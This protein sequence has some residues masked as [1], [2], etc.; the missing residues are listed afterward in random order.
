MNLFTTQ[1]ANG[2]ESV[3]ATGHPSECQEPVIGTVSGSEPHSVTV[4][5]KNGVEQTIATY[6]HAVL[7]FPKH[8]HDYGDVD[9]CHDE[10]SH[11]ID[12]ESGNLNKENWSLSVSINP[13]NEPKTPTLIVNNGVGT[14]PKTSERVNSIDSGINNSIREKNP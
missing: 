13:A 14:D 11:N 6:G 1:D 5:N 10:E 7:Q 8:D 4:N 9:G 3:E 12:K 2:S